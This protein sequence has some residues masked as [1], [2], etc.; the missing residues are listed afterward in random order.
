MSTL[1]QTRSSDSVAF[2]GNS[3]QNLGLRLSVPNPREEL[4]DGSE[5]VVWEKL[6]ENIW[7]IPST[8][9]ARQESTN[10]DALNHY[11]EM[12]GLGV[13]ET[14]GQDIS[15]VGQRRNRLHTVTCL[16]MNG[17]ASRLGQLCRDRVK[18]RIARLTWVTFSKR[19]W[20]LERS[21]LEIFKF[22]LF[23]GE[24]TT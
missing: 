8:I 10:E 3:F 11:C 6:V 1:A 18:G 16:T 17:C 7:H 19:P 15:I 14:C 12:S 22:D 9:C 5:L 23:N 4:F 13:S 20:W 21:S 2:C 24:G